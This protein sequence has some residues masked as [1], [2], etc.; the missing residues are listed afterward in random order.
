MEGHT[1]EE[2]ATMLGLPIGT[3]EIAAVCGPQEI[4]GEV[5]MYVTNIKKR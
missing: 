1:L 3:V 4:S 5:A 2:V